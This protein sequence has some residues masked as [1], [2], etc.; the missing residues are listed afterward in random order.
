VAKVIYLETT[1]TDQNCVHE[2]I[3]RRLNSGSACYHSVQCLLSSRLLSRN[4]EV[5]IY[6]TIILPVVLYRRQTSSLTL[7]EE[8][9]L[10]V[11]EN[12]VLRRIFGPKR[13]EVAEEWRKLHGREL[14]N[15]YLFPNIIRQIKS[16]KM[17]WASHMTF[18]GEEGKVCKVLVRKPKERHHSKT[19]SMAEWEQDGS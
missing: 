19:K 2:E 5:K 16:R 10:R 18:V 14:H 12:R 9:I 15:F 7:R 8:H 13:V 11:F 3:K 6:K 1:P 17:G 4:V